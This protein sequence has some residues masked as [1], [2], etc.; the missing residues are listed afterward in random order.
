MTKRNSCVTGSAEWLALHSHYLTIADHQMRDWF[1]NEPD[2]YSRFSLE[3]DGILLDYSR[4]R[5]TNE[6]I[7]LLTKLANACHLPDRIKDLFEGAKLN[8]T[9][10]RAALHT[11]LRDA[12]A[13][14]IWQDGSDIA[15]DIG[16]ALAQ[17]AEFTQ[18]IH[19]QQWRGCTGL[20]I[21]HIVTI[22]VG[23][24]YL[25][26]M[27]CVEALKDSAISSLQFH[28][29]STVD[30]ALLNDVL[31]AIDPAA[32]LFIISSKTFSTMETMT[33]A[34]TLLTWM[35]Q[36]LGQSVIA[37][38]FIAITA[39]HD[40]A[41][42]FG[43][44]AN[45]IFPLWDWVGGRFSVWSAVG[46]PVMLMIGDKG[47][48]DFLAGAHEMDIHF[49]NAPF[50]QNIPVLLALLSLWYRN[51]FNVSAQAI[52]PYSYRLR[53]FVAYLQ[54][55]DM[56]SNGKR[57]SKE[58]H[59]IEYATG[60]VIFGEEGCNGQHSYHQLL[61]QG[62]HLIPVDFI[63]TGACPTDSTTSA[64]VAALI[65]QQQQILLAS[66]LSQAQALMQGK[67]LEA[68]MSALLKSGLTQ[69][70]AEKL[71]PHQVNPGNRP[72]N[73]IYLT[74]LTPKTLGSLMAMYEHKIFVQGVMWDINSFDQWGVELGKQLLPDILSRVQGNPSKTE[75]D[76]ATAGMIHHYNSLK[77][78][79]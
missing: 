54:Q 64:S 9:E 46:L 38:H 24:S 47:F 79:V 19:Q 52:V 58:G 56:E 43:I 60:P 62:Q 71:A 41:L 51:F 50:A 40:A 57:I 68:A 32:T 12:S 42:A 7:H 18:L 27:M 4:N 14:P 20:P 2:R 74:K 13:L 29:I 72:S 1:N 45:N 36:T 61:H 78:K 73:I 49:R 53:D 77:G 34:R 44:P 5:I 65:D 16:A 26:T 8:S 48:A 6:T 76:S 69:T 15:P 3:I 55:A 23:G 30:P 67:S 10:K 39:N 17:M 37:E 75:T 63:L 31:H 22:G 59:D 70:A 33:N 66:G 21:K 11:A 28:F 25:G 35:Q